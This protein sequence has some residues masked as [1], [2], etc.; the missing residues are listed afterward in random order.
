MFVR[1]GQ[2]KLTQAEVCWWPP[3]GFWGFPVLPDGDDW[4]FM[5]WCVGLLEA[6]GQCFPVVCVQ[7]C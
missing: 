3:V 1:F 6:A 5:T 7:F 4:S 2:I